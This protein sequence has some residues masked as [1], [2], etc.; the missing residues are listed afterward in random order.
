VLGPDGALYI[1]E[2]SGVPFTDGRANVYRLDPGAD[3]PHA[4]TL[5][6]AFL[7]GFK[8]IVDMTFDDEGNLYVLEHATGQF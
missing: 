6:E 7:T 8:M 5:A 4:F 1:S 2:L 3:I